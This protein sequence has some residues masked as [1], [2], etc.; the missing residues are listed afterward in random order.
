[1]ADDRETTNNLRDDGK[2]CYTCKKRALKSLKEIKI[3]KTAW[4]PRGYFLANFF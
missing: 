1:M 2:G 4:L 3:E